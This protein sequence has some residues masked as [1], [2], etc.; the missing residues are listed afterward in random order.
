MAERGKILVIGKVSY[1]LEFSISEQFSLFAPEESV[2]GFTVGSD[3]KRVFSGMAGNVAYGLALLGS[4]PIL[5]SQVGNDFDWFYR[6]HLEKHEVE[7]R[8]FIDPEKE[9]AC[10]YKITDAQEKVLEILQDNCYRFLAEGDL[11]EQ[12]EPKMFLDLT[13]AFIGTGKVEADAKFISTIHGHNKSLPLIYSPDANVHELTKWRLSQIFEKITVLV[14]TE[15]ELKLIEERMKA[16][17]DEILANST[18][19]KYVIS[20]LQ[21]SK[22][23][24]HSKET[25]VKVSEGPAEEIFS[26]DGWQDAFRAG[27]IY[28]VS[29]KRPID[30]AAKLG[31]ALASYA[32][33][34][35]EYQQYSPSFEQVSLR[36]FEVKTIS[37]N[38]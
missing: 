30:E 20:I 27:L 31:S 28:G 22:I 17:R 29:L 14:C 9:T 2:G 35:H 12:F 6:S 18:R 4:P 1:G 24:I 25:R 15:D 26:D 36:A 13:V 32:V 16:S 10:Q 34:T 23:I 7:M 5:V 11:E 19:L 21:R 38:K 37:K 3:V 8:L 33:E